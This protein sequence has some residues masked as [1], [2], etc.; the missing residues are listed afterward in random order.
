MKPILPLF[1]A[2]ALVPLLGGCS[3]DSDR[4][5]TAA[6]GAAADV[7]RQQA[8]DAL[9]I[10]ESQKAIMKSHLGGPSVANPADAAKAQSAGRQR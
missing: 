4:K 9:N 1:A 10:P 2:L 6:E 7:K 5:P 8:I 3:D